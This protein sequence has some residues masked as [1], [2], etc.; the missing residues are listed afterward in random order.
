MSAIYS[1]GWNKFLATLKMFD[2]Y[3]IGVIY[4][5]FAINL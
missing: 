4:S 1:I 3:G 2:P 5:F